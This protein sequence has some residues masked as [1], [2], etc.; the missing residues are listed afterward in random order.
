M[1]VI[2]TWFSLILLFSQSTDRRTTTRIHKFAFLTTKVTKNGEEKELFANI[3]MCAKGILSSFFRRFI[4]LIYVG[5]MLYVDA[6]INIRF[7]YYYTP[8]NSTWRRKEL[9][10]ARRKS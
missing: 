10:N 6:D 5:R 7:F 4:S 3:K 1:N 2:I 8:F 9:L